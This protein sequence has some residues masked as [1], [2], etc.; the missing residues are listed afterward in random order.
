MNSICLFGGTILGAA[1]T[2]KITGKKKNEMA[3]LSEKHLSLFLMMNQWVKVKQ[4]KKELTDFFLRNG[5]KKIAIYGM[6]Y[7]G[8]TLL[9]ELKT[10]EVK[11]AYGIDK[12]ARF[13]CSDVDVFSPEDKLEEVDAIVVT[14]IAYFDEIEEKLLEKV[15]CPILSFEDILYDV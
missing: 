11:V 14:A 13:V 12:N 5:Y 8:E 2:G 15:S 4:D 1:I 9:E 3:H 6:S 7:V 10:S